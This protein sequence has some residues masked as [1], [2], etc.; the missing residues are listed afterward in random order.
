[1][2]SLKTPPMKCHSGWHR[3]GQSTRALHTEAT[4]GRAGN[5]HGADER[6]PGYM[7]SQQDIYSKPGLGATVDKETKN[8][9]KL[10]TSNLDQWESQS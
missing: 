6:D 1:M 7:Y 4:L 3:T 8:P 10:V 9:W 2:N 5:S